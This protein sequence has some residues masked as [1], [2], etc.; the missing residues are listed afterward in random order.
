M[1]PI[2]NGCRRGEL[3]SNFEH[4]LRKHRNKPPARLRSGLKDF[5]CQSLRY[6]NYNVSGEAQDLVVSSGPKLCEARLTAR[7]ASRRDD[8]HCREQGFGKVFSLF[9]GTMYQMT[10]LENPFSDFPHLCF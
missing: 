7:G 3:L 6:V 1:L 9:S 10:I 2:G 8:L 5:S 4:C